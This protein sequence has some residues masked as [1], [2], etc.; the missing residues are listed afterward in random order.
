MYSS[1]LSPEDHPKIERHAQ[2]AYSRSRECA[3]PAEDDER[4]LVLESLSLLRVL[5]LASGNLS[6]VELP[7]R[8]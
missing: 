5:E 2:T 7:S 8:V 1:S 3:F 6:G 4:S